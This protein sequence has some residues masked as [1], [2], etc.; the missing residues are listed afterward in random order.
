MVPNVRDVITYS[1]W[2]RIEKEREGKGV[3]ER[4]NER[5]RE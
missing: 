3:S 4:E 2:M 1:K 5:E